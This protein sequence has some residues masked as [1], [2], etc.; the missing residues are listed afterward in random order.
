MTL[1]RIVLLTA[2]AVG[3]IVLGGAGVFF[4]FD[5][6]LFGMLALAIAVAQTFVIAFLW[7]E[8]RQSR[9]D[10]D[11]VT[12]TIDGALRSVAQAANR[13]ETSIGELT[14]AM[15]RSLGEMAE[16]RSASDV[17]SPQSTTS[18]S[19]NIVPL[20][21]RKSK[22]LSALSQ[23]TAAP[24]PEDIT[25]PLTLSLEPIV[26]ATENT[27]VAFEAY[28]NITLANGEERVVRRLGDAVSIAQ[29]GTFELDLF[30][31]AVKAGRRHLGSGQAPIHV[32]LS[33]DFLSNPTSVAHVTDMLRVHSGL[34]TQIVLSVA[35]SLDELSQPA[36]S[37]ALVRLG[38]VGAKLVSEAVPA[39]EDAT[40][41]LAGLGVVAIKLGAARLLDLETNRGTARLGSEIVH[42]S[43][44][45]GLETIATGVNTDHDVLA[46][47]DIGVNQMAG[48]RFSPPRRLRAE[49]ADPSEQAAS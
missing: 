39:D 37:A 40:R 3:L 5:G 10:L 48:E 16:L 34:A 4:S 31:A 2:V 33:V 49:A 17:A 6:R 24:V 12:R 30:D 7:R 36:I 19:T 13:N 45:A 29:R 41:R 27:V 46:L 22:T 44:V 21:V 25:G 35:A 9:R 11:R 42:D 20:P 43:A 28:A 14:Q 8:S 18:N 32:A 15:N 47:L 26:D 23:V 1:N 38:Q